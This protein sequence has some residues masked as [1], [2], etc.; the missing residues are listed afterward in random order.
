M[1]SRKPWLIA[2][3]FLL[4]FALGAS[5]AMATGYF[6]GYVRPSGDGGPTCTTGFSC[7]SPVSSGNQFSIPVDLFGV[8]APQTLSYDVLDYL[9]NDQIGAGSTT[10]FAIDALSLNSLNLQAGDLLTFTFSALQGVPSDK[11]Q[12]V[13]GI[14]S[15]VKPNSTAVAT[16]I[17]DSMGGFVSSKCTNY[18]PSAAPLITDES[19]SLSGNSITFSINP[20]LTTFPSQFAFSFPDG[21][22]PTAIEVEAGPVTTPE[23]ASMTL[24]AAG[25]IGLGVFRRKRTV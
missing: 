18:L 5:S 3:G 20:S 14:L 6:R 11:N 16:T 1:H 25:L 23:P 9:S 4:V 21:Q 8:I 7:T 13:F 17:V 15:C 2:V 12:T 19:V 22:R 24:L 10:A